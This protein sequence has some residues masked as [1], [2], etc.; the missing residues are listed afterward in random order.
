MRHLLCYIC[1][2]PRR[3]KVEM[4]N[5]MPVCPACR[6]EYMPKTL[7]KKVDEVDFELLEEDTDPG[8]GPPIIPSAKEVYKSLD[9]S[10]RRVVD[11]GKKGRLSQDAKKLADLREELDKLMTF[12]DTKNVKLETSWATIA[13]PYSKANG[14]PP[15]VME[16]IL[17]RMGGRRP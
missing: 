3:P 2:D 6:Y 13:I 11:T 4:I 15:D 5:D 16:R 1:A 7:D 12:D 17:H 14:G 9:K 10:K 8:F